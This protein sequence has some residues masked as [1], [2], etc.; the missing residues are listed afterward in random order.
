MST[1]HRRPPMTLAAAVRLPYAWLACIAAAYSIASAAVAAQQSPEQ[2]Y[3]Q[4]PA[5]LAPQNAEASP[6]AA[7]DATGWGTAAGL[8]YLEI[9]RGG[10]RP[11]EKLPLLLVIHGLGDKPAPDWVRAVDVDDNLKVRMIL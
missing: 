8:R 5:A 3:S 2:S 4:P 9:I 11:N 1:T 6:D 10:A 7:P